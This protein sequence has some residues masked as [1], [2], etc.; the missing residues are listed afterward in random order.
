MAIRE[1]K[2][3]SLAD[4]IVARQG[5]SM[6][7]LERLDGLVDWGRVS[8]L[9]AP[10]EPS[11]RGAPGYPA[12]PLYK[13]LLLQQW[14]AL[15]DPGLE[16]AV[17]DRLSFRRFVGLSLDEPA[18][19]HS[20]VCRFRNG[21]I[22]QGLTERL[23]L[24]V[25]RQIDAQ[26]LVL[27]Q[28]TMIDASLVEAQ[29]KRP[30]KP[31]DEAV[32]EEGTPLEATPAIGGPTLA[33]GGPTL[34]GRGPT[35]GG[36]GPS[37]LVAS[38]T[39]PEASWAKKGH[40]RYFGYKAHVAVDFLSGVIRRARLTTAAVADT[41]LGDDLIIGDERAVYADQAYDKKAR[42]A[43]L[44]SAG[45]KDRIAHRPNRHHPLTARQEQRNAGISRRRSGV[46][47]VFAAPKQQM[48]WRRVRY[49]GLARNAGHFDLICTVL[50]LK[51]WLRLVEGAPA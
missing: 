7:T 49:I 26:G 6:V 42:R 20:T 24:E 9:L 12:L 19:D 47:R 45:I 3:L 43:F 33:I 2:Q 48:N 11:R 25:T 21:L 39:D 27:R 30:K 14:Y 34:G 38:A 41:S 46:E 1:M 50:N 40:R 5:R 18:P 23:F 13:M 4:G 10:M 15:S 31:Q 17:A 22:A 51:R 35:L 28:G 32:S 8:A 37:K 44:K 29:V 36:R 16:D